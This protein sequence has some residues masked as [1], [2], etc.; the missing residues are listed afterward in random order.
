MAKVLPDALLLL[1]G[2]VVIVIAIKLLDRVLP[3][4]D[5]T[6]RVG[7]DGAGRRSHWALFALGFG[8][9]LVTFSVSVALT[10]LVPMAARGFINRREAVPYIMG[11]NVATLVDTLLVAFLYNN[12]VGVQIVLAEAIG[13]AAV[14]LLCLA[15]LYRPLSRSVLAIDDWVVGTNRRLALFAVSLFVFP[16]LLVGVGFLMVK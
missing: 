11:A 1:L 10:V 13:V 4:F 6:R 9:T 7:G 14:T 12:A 15:L 8:V 3:E 16:A 2:G 5:L